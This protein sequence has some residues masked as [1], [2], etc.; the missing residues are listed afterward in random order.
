[1]VPDSIRVMG[2]VV[3]RRALVGLDDLRWWRQLAPTLERIFAKTY[4]ETAPHSY[5]VQEG[6]RV[7]DR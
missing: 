1:M 4:A 5:V 7:C 2:Y 6:P 3:A